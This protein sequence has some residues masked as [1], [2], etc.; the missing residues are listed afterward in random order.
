MMEEA[1]HGAVSSSAH[2][3]IG[4]DGMVRARHQPTGWIGSCF[5]TVWGWHG[6]WVGSHSNLSR[7][8]APVEGTA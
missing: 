4:R 3:R 8:R 6:G 1:S 7:A 5:S 2:P